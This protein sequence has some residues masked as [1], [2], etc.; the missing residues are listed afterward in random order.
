[1][2]CSPATTKGSEFRFGWLDRGIP[3]FKIKAESLADQLGTRPGLG[4][5]DLL[6]LPHH[7]WW[8][9]NRHRLS[10]SHGYPECY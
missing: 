2:K 6:E 10:G 9:G 7:C 1:M 3:A 5:P 4:P 8:Q